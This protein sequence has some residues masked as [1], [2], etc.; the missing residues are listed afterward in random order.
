M[1]QLIEQ[2]NGCYTDF[3]SLLPFMPKAPEA[4]KKFII[5]YHDRVLFGT[6]ATT[7]WPGLVNQYIETVKELIDDKI[8]LKKIFRGNYLTV[9]QKRV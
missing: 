3:S 6:D 5:G 8:V 2:F 1:A 7:D 9:H 4:Y